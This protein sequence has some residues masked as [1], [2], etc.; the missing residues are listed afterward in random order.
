MESEGRQ[1]QPGMPVRFRQQQLRPALQHAADQPVCCRVVPCEGCVGGYAVQLGARRQLV[2]FI[3][4]VQDDL[5]RGLQQVRTP[6]HR[7]RV[8]QRDDVDQLETLSRALASM[9]ALRSSAPE[10]RSSAC[11]ATTIEPR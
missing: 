9:A 10:D 6:A 4:I 11:T 7:G 2:Q 3:L 8:G 5:P 1:R